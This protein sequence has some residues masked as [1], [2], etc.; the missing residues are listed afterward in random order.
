[1]VNN[2]LTHPSSFILFNKVESWEKVVVYLKVEIMKISAE[3][4]V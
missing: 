4:N 2:A 1:M 3:K